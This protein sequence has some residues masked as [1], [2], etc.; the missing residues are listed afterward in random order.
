MEHEK[1][2]KPEKKVSEMRIVVEHIYIYR[3][4]RWR[5]H[6]P[7]LRTR[8]KEKGR[9]RARRPHRLWLDFLNAIA[10]FTA[11]VVIYKMLE[12]PALMERGYKNYGGECLAAAV[13]G[14]LV[15]YILKGGDKRG[16]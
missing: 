10:S 13:A 3:Y 8:K 1:S 16:I 4:P 7:K 2:T 5:V 15:F 14:M 9:S 11:C 12:L 6:M